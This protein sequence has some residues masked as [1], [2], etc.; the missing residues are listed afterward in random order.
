MARCGNR[1]R[2]SSRPLAA[3]V[4][5][6]L[7]NFAH[8]RHSAVQVNSAALHS[9]LKLLRA[10]RWL[11]CRCQ[12]SLPR[13][14]SAIPA[15]LATRRPDTARVSLSLAQC[16][17]GASLRRAG[18]FRP[19]MRRLR[20]KRRTAA[21]IGGLTAARVPRERSCCSARRLAASC[22]AMPRCSA[23]PTIAAWREC[24]LALP[25]AI[26]QAARTMRAP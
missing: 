17:G 21:S 14:P 1:A 8:R 2:K 12:R 7:H 9:A 6:Q 15:H 10:L 16:R 4:P 18:A 20:S 19:R 26:L 3:A 24:H 11:S 23:R 22:P 5:P 25:I 13:R